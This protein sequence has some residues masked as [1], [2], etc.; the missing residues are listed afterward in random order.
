MGSGEQFFICSIYLS[1][2]ITTLIYFSQLVIDFSLY[3]EFL[4]LLMVCLDKWVFL[5]CFLSWCY[6]TN[7]LHKVKSL[8]WAE[9]VTVGS[10]GFVPCVFGYCI[11]KLYVG[12]TRSLIYIFSFIFCQ[13]KQALRNYLRL[14]NFSGF[15]R[16]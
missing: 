12:N 1:N 8:L 9:S 7:R 15:Q 10:Y 14:W 13:I 4:L 3:T 2:V 16:R 6:I 11:W 5:L